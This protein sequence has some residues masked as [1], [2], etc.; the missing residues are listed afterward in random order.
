[1]KLLRLPTICLSLIAGHILVPVHPRAAG[2]DDSVV[3][4]REPQ[5]TAY[6]L[7]P[8]PVPVPGTPAGQVAA[9]GASDWRRATAADDPEITVELGSRIV[10]QVNPQTALESVLKG[11]SLTVARTVAPGMYLLQAANSAAAITAAAALAERPEVV[12]SYPIMRRPWRRQGPLA[13]A[14]N[15]PRFDEQWHLDH[16]GG[17]RNLIGP[18]L[19]ARGAW[20]TTRGEGVIVGVGDDG[21]QTSHPDLSTRMASGLSYNFFREISTGVP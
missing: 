13:P 14:P 16:R 2:G 6:R 9:P 21:V 5:A 12:A 8:V 7:A 11:H 3:R 1:M 10:L 15:D 20:P 4:F 19:N 18:D 17:D